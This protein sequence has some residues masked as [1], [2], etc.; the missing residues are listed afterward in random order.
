M[1]PNI[2]GSD[3][4][5]V[6]CSQRQ[7][8]PALKGRGRA[9]SRSVARVSS[10]PGASGGAVDRRITWHD[11]GGAQKKVQLASCALVYVSARARAVSYLLQPYVVTMQDYGTRYIDTVG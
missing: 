1:E 9:K 7:R 5:A 6:R 10:E 4:L 2:L 3:S 11:T 8:A